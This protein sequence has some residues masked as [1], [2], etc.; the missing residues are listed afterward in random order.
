MAGAVADTT[1]GT[2]VLTPAGKKAIWGAFFGFWVDFYDIYLP[3]VALT[4]ALIYFIPKGLPVQTAATLNFLVFTVTLIGRPIGSFIFGHLGDVIGRKRTTIIAVSGFTVMTFLIALLPG[5]ATWGYASIALLITLRLVDGMFF[6]GEYTSANPLAMEACP[7]RLRGFVGGFIQS[8]YPIAYVAISATVLVVFLFA[9]AGKLGSACVQWGW[10]IP[11]VIGSLLGL[12]FLAYYVRVEESRLWESQ[13]KDKVKAPLVDLFSGQNLRNLVQVFLLMTGLWFVVQV[14]I[15]A[16]P[17]FLQT[18]LKQP[19][20]GGHLRAPRCQHL[21]LGELLPDRLAEP[22]VRPQVMFAI[23]GVTTGV[24]GTVGYGLMLANASA[25]GS[26]VVTMAI[27]TVVL[28]LTLSPWGIVTSYINERFPTGVRASGFG[29]GYS[30]AVVIPSLVLFYLPAIAKLGI[31][32]LYTPL[33]L[34]VL[35][36]LFQVLGAL[37]GPETRDVDMT[38]VVAPGGRDTQS[39]AATA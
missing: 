1:S 6:G 35:A 14:S 3:T 17:T 22:E 7:K 11:F 19:A 29:V 23:T 33:V 16:T 37:L 39:R 24:V 21:P 15:T 38:S 31:P 9:P 13:A 27:F 32:Y 12:A 28:C 25:K 8:A 4:P 10:R 5:Y 18:V 20:R 36:G 26:L 30:L 2:D 34:M